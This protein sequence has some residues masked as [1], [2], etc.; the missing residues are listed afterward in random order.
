MG[1][2][3]DY[4]RYGAVLYS[5]PQPDDRLLA[6]KRKLMW[7][8]NNWTQEA[9]AD[10]WTTNTFC[11]VGLVD[12]DVSNSTNVQLLQKNEDINFVSILKYT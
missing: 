1:Y 8:G 6:M 9:T 4:F 10:T 12:P 3:D 5:K 2:E 7:N 11:E